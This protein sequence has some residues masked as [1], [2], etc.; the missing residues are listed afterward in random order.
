MGLQLAERLLS[1]THSADSYR[2]PTLTGKCTGLICFQL[3]YHTIDQTL[4]VIMV[5]SEILVLTYLPRRCSSASTK[6]RK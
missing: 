2:L 1:V 4:S 3:A 5:A 6:A